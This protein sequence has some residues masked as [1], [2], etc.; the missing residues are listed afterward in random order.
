MH[1]A[2]LSGP[3][4]FGDKAGCLALD[5]FQFVDVLL[6][7]SIDSEQCMLCDNIPVSSLETVV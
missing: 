4:V 6:Q 2:R 5:A 7:V 3:I 1:P